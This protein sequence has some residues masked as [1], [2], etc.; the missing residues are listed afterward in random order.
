[1]IFCTFPGFHSDHIFRHGIRT[2]PNTPIVLKSPLLEELF[3]YD[4]LILVRDRGRS[5]QDKSV[6][7]NPLSAQ[8]W[9]EQ[10]IP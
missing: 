6:Q 3:Q 7:D 9:L 8:F 10:R 5:V 1:M 4:I 2:F